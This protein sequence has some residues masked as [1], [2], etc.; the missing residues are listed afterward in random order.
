MSRSVRQGGEQRGRLKECR[1][2][3][4]ADKPDERYPGV[5]AVKRV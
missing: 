3:L 1:N 2:R 4:R 5:H